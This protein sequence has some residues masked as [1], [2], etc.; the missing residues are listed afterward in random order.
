MN[1]TI[2]NL[3]ATKNTIK[4]NGVMYASATYLKNNKK[5]FNKDNFVIIGS[6]SYYLP[7]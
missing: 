6:T 7:I 2:N 3:K 5:N 4:L 1:N